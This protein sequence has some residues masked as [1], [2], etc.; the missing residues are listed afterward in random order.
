MVL[1]I[2]IIDCHGMYQNLISPFLFGGC[3]IRADW[4][5]V[6][7]NL[8]KIYKRV[9][10][11]SGTPEEFVLLPVAIPVL[12]A[13]REMK[14]ISHLQ[15]RCLFHPSWR[16]PRRG[17]CLGKSSRFV[18]W[19]DDPLRPIYF[20]QIFQFVKNHTNVCIYIR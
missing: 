19:V 1:C 14:I 12:H 18:C 11:S 9:E 6:F 17:K 20:V 7:F 10:T 3:P 5:C 16:L 8:L 13:G 4:V 2:R 15:F